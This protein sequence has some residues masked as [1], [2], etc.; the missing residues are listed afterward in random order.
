MGYHIV[1]LGRL[2]QRAADVW[3]SA[4]FSS[5]F[6]ASSFSYISGR[7]HTRPHAANA[8]RW[9]AAIGNILIES[10]GYGSLTDYW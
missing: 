8:N 7:I 3:D 10:E 4:R 1:F 5:I 9:A 6:L 2:T